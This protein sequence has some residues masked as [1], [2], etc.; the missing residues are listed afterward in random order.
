MMIYQ[1][2]RSFSRT[3]D[4]FPS[5][6]P[7]Y[8][9]QCTVRVS[10]LFFQ[11]CTQVSYRTPLSF[12]LSFSLLLFS[13]FPGRGSR[14]RRGQ[15]SWGPRGAAK[16]LRQLR[17]WRE[18]G[19]S[20][21]EHHMTTMQNHRKRPQ[22]TGWSWAPRRARATWRGSRLRRG[23][24]SWGAREATYA[25]H[26]HRGRENV[27]EASEE[28]M[29]WR[30][31]AW[32]GDK[33]TVIPM[34]AS[35]PSAECSALLNSSCGRGRR[36]PFASATGAGSPKKRYT[37]SASICVAIVTKHPHSARRRCVPIS[38]AHDRRNFASIFTPRK[39]GRKLLLRKLLRCKLLS[40]CPDVCC[41]ANPKVC[42]TATLRPAQVACCS[43]WLCT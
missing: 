26:Q 18:P 37:V 1:C 32:R 34:R 29:Q 43:P 13:L 6:C 39:E 42:C 15:T 19:H 5:S 23:Q 2:H 21:A 33:I 10:M 41:I 8:E 12:P 35:C 28:T 31:H 24:T 22:W 4:L 36:T 14:L 20:W 25:R 16:G 27:R 7:V 17:L 30:S 38:L 11:N 40:S 3:H 9:A